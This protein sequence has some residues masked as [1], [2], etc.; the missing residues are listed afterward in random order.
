MPQSPKLTFHITAKTIDQKWFKKPM[1][2][3]WDEL[4]K[5]LYLAHRIHGGDIICF[6]LMN[7]HYH[8]LLKTQSKKVGKFISFLCPDVFQN[9]KIQSIASRT[10]LLHC[11]RYNYQNPTRAN[12]LK[13]IEHYPYSTLYNLIHGKRSGAPIHEKFGM[14]DEYKLHWLNRPVSSKD[15]R[16]VRHIDALKLPSPEI[17]L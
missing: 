10:Y 3:M 11:Y 5:G 16:K 13:K 2:A 8:L 6:V 1:N 12:L 15:L 4:L 9:L 17:I 7:N 14:P